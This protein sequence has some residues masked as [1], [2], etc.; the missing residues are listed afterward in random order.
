[1]TDADTVLREFKFYRRRPTNHCLFSLGGAVRW[2][3]T[4]DWGA[5]VGRHLLL[6]G[7]AEGFVE[8]GVTSGA[9]PEGWVVFTR[10]I[11]RKTTELWGSGNPGAWK[12]GAFM[13]S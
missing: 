6:P 5:H 13:V 10:S 3:Y 12:G 7:E 9:D 1:M 4:T 2:V 8:E 11:R